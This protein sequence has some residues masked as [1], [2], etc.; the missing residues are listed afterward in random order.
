MVPSGL[1]M[2]IGAREVLLGL[3]LFIVFIGAFEFAVVSA[4]PIAANLIPGSTGVGLGAAVGAGTFGRAVMSAIATALYDSH[5]FAAPGLVGASLALSA[6]L[7]TFAYS[8]TQRVTM[9][10]AN[11]DW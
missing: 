6:G 3:L 5:G 9:K 8:R 4:L 10:D 7:L 1:L 11:S 2:V